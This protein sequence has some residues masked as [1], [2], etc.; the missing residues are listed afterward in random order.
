MN[1]LRELMSEN[2]RLRVQCDDLTHRNDKLRADLAA[3]REQTAAVE[4][5]RD[6]ARK[7][8]TYERDSER[9]RADGFRDRAEAAER[10]VSKLTNERDRWKLQSDDATKRMWETGHENSRLER[11]VTKLRDVLAA[12]T[13][14]VVRQLTEINR[15]NREQAVARTLIQE[16]WFYSDVRLYK[17]WEMRARPALSSPSTPA[18]EVMEHEGALV[19]NAPSCAYGCYEGL[20]DEN[21]DVHG[22]DPIEAPGKVC[23]C[24][25]VDGPPYQYDADCP[26]HAP[27]IPTTEGE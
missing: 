1:G 24:R 26:F 21:C 11:E 27:T 13:D 3:S 10:E 19:G 15:L 23:R 2:E 5:E 14:E 7:W 12:Q 16:A 8:L 6:E 20:M 4:R 17:D 9:R 18:G 22:N 25:S